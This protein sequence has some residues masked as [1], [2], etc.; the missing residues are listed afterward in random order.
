M[1]I[2]R[3]E[4]GWCTYPRHFTRASG[5]NFRRTPETKSTYNSISRALNQLSVRGLVVWKG[6]DRHGAKEPI[7][8]APADFWDRHT[9]KMRRHPWNFRGYCLTAEGFAIGAATAASYDHLES[10]LSD[11]DECT[12]ALIIENFYTLA[13]YQRDT[14]PTVKDVTVGG[15]QSLRV[16]NSYTG[17]VSVGDIPT[18]K[19]RQPIDAEAQP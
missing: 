3:T 7:S 9:S 19:R 2:A 8:L 11:L 14:V 10:A 5:T 16:A 15:A 4:A 6:T 18:P 12:R 13:K 17:T 1:P